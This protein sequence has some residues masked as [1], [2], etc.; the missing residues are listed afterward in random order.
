MTDHSESCEAQGKL[1]EAL[2]LV[3]SCQVELHGMRRR[4]LAA[5]QELQALRQARQPLTEEIAALRSELRR[6][7][8][9]LTAERERLLGEL[10]RRSA[11]LDAT[12]G[13]MVDGVV[14]YAADGQ[15]LFANHAADNIL[16]YT[17][18]ERATTDLVTRSRLMSFVA[19]DGSYLD[20]EQTPVAKALR[21]EAST[22]MV[23]RV[24]RADAEI[25]I[26]VSTSPVRGPDGEIRGAV[27]T[28]RDITQS[29]QMENQ[30]AWLASFPQRN[31]M[32][33][34]EVSLSGQVH[35]LNPSARDLFSQLEDQKLAHP[36]LSDWQAAVAALRASP[37]LA[38]EREIAV[39]DRH[40][41]QSWHLLPEVDR[42][43]I[44]GRDITAHVL[45][46][47]ALRESEQRYSVIFESAPFA[48][49][50]TKLP[51]GTTVG[52]NDAFL[53]LFQLSRDEVIGKT[54]LEL[55]I[56]DAEAQSHLAEELRNKGRV[57]DFEC[58]RAARPGA[59]VFLSLNVDLVTIGG[60]PFC[61]TTIHDITRGKQAERSLHEANQRLRE[62]DLHKNEFLAMLSHE[63][64]NPL[65]PIRNSLH[66]L[67]RVAPDGDSAR[68][69]RAIIERQTAHV[70]RLVDD[71]L[72]I[73]RISRGGIR[74]QRRPVEM[75]EVVSRST[76]DLRA[77]F[78]E[79]GIGLTLALP[80]TPIWIDG[81]GA[82]LVQ[83]VGNLLHNT[84]KF[85]DRGGRV[86]VMLAA[87]GGRA[88]LRVRDTGVGIAREMLPR[89][90]EPFAQAERTL[91]R[92]KGGLGLGL[93]LVKSLVQLHGGE[94][95]AHSEGPGQGAEFVVHLPVIPAPPVLAQEA[96]VPAP[97][98]PR[99]RVLVIEDNVDAALSLCEV[100]EL[101][102]H[103]VSVAYQGP[104]G[105][106][107]AS[108]LRPDVVLCDIGLPGMDGYEVARRLRADP[109]M[110][111]VLLVALS[112]Y[113]LPEDLQRAAAAGFDRHIAKPPSVE[114]IEET[115]AALQ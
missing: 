76:E 82:R 84:L 52:V 88:V 102:G 65:A 34:A 75:G 4:M 109:T 60:Q 111:G 114:Q 1:A 7:G 22:R 29:R 104:E 63:L 61:L 43:R 27:S 2:A 66:T 67:G 12:L 35:Y 77:L 92:S 10:Q 113:T 44:Y 112:G 96:P 49:A 87:S 45:T 90:F 54:S 78:V 83:T 19:E 72:D 48:I 16:R 46:E 23:L 107:K 106:A 64:R 100:L 51:E 47:R 81:D 30:M 57:R 37:N 56:F 79:K 25:W 36:W 24:P 73:T 93:A 31:P 98:S 39:A 68:Q 85:T 70:T 38:W 58:S 55:G 26:S 94:V 99:R 71:L 80:E 97:A 32:P 69:A 50:L 21:G 13:S 105:L 18:T 40:Y 89:L 108:E 74:L 20:P 6:K 17:A 103:E 11:E 115:L 3:E 110:A 8:E 62:A 14:I 9:E 15:R 41:H 28:V 101:G 42:I 86:W 91:D 33:I 5:E 59:R 53:R 95:N